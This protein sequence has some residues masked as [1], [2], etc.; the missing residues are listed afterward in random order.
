MPI[1]VQNG[2]NKGIALFQ[3][4][5]KNIF[6][7][8][9]LIFK[10]NRP[11]KAK[12]KLYHGVISSF[13][14]SSLMWM[15][16]GEVCKEPFCF[17]ENW[18]KFLTISLLSLNSAWNFRY[19]VS[20]FGFLLFLFASFL[21]I[22]QTNCLKKPLL[23]TESPKRSFFRGFS[24]FWNKID[25]KKHTKNFNT[26]WT[27][28]WFSEAFEQQRRLQSKQFSVVDPHQLN[29]RKNTLFQSKLNELPQEV[30]L[31]CKFC[32]TVHMQYFENSIFVVFKYP[33]IPMAN[34]LNKSIAFFQKCKRPLF[35]TF[36]SFWN[37]ID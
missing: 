29:L 11:K 27:V 2:L 7:N 19:N 13:M 5:K 36:S 4:C 31:A 34:S 9:L 28:L 22:S 14:L 25:K 6:Q 37:E 21:E 12:P 15:Y 33:S 32:L 10:Q 26:A 3:K 24:S 8:S 35:R 16:V 23:P 1:P 30:S 18:M 20:K 17:E